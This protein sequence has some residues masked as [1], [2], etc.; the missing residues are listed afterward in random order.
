MMILERWRHFATTQ[1]T[2]EHPRSIACPRSWSL[3]DLQCL[4]QSQ[5]LLTQNRVPKG[6]ISLFSI[7]FPIKKWF[8]KPGMG[9]GDALSI[10]MKRTVYLRWCLGL[11]SCFLD[12]FS[13]SALNLKKTVDVFLHAILITRVFRTGSIA[14]R[15]GKLNGI[16]NELENNKIMFL[17]IWELLFDKRETFTR[18]S[19]TCVQLGFWLVETSK[20]CELQ[21]RR[22]LENGWFIILGWIH[23]CITMHTALFTFKS[24]RTASKIFS[25]QSPDQLQKTLVE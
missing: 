1:V 14:P 12:L 10:R 22:G 11:D 17:I 8:R 24:K 21:R 23:F 2:P 9:R 4:N 15:F 25:R 7:T 20:S 19:Q 5:K 3:W 6:K 16:L 13:F 18:R